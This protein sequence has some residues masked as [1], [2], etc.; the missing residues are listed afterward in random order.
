MENNALNKKGLFDY[1]NMI[2]LGIVALITVYPF[3]YVLS[4]SLSG[5]EA[6]LAQEVWLFPKGFS[7]ES[8]KL[9]TENPG[10]IRAYGN[11][12]VYVVLG[13]IL[14]IF[15]TTSTAYALSRKR[16]FARKF[17][18]SFITLTMIV[19]GGLIPGFILVNKLGMYN[20]RWVMIILGAVSPWLLLITRTY[21]DSSIPESLIEAA[22]IDGYT[23]LGIYAT[24]VM[25]LIRPI[26][27]VL[28]LFYGVAHWNEWFTALIYIVD[29]KLEPLQIFLR[30]VLVLQ[31]QDYLTGLVGVERLAYRQQ[32]KYASIILAVA[33]L[34]CAYPF[35]QKHFIKGV[36]VGAVKE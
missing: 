18:L 9:I 26:I 10:M 16:F 12:I 22:S 29:P 33:P 35:M 34:L 20:T 36:M 32:L 1:I 23:D 3:V 27:A 14:N 31:T 11:T 2:L 6:I 19:S 5:P 24:L 28:V 15:L 17:L 13:T 4:M 25:P 8:Y 7:L 21:I 30:K